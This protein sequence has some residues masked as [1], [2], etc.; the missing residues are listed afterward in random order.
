MQLDLFK[1]RLWKYSTGNL[2]SNLKDEIKKLIDQDS[3]RNISNINSWQS[4]NIAYNETFTSLKK[5]V[6]TM[7]TEPLVQYGIDTLNIK[8][9]IDDMWANCNPKDGFNIVHDHAG[10]NNFFSFC[11]YVDVDEKN[12]YIS[13]KNENPSVR[14]I[15]LPKKQDT[16]I[17]ST[18]VVVKVVNGDLLIFP[19]WIEHYTTQN[20]SSNNRISIAGNVKVKEI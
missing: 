6:Q 2:F 15:N 12:G 20:Q 13:F 1:T 3:G 16:D 10:E 17:N 8:I 18:D 19:S 5:H 9:S 14:F 4:N 7:V 11:F